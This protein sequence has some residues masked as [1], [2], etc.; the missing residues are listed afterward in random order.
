MGNEA[1]IRFRPI[2][3]TTAVHS[4]RQGEET[5]AA[6]VFNCCN[7]CTSSLL[8]LERAESRLRLSPVTK[9]FNARS[10]TFCF[11]GSVVR[12]VELETKSISCI[13]VHPSKLPQNGTVAF[14]KDCL[15]FTSNQLC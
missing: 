5:Y 1:G 11:A 7:V 9:R 4:V 14:V 8:V 12:N 2:E 6:E 15:S 13:S 3:K 10:S